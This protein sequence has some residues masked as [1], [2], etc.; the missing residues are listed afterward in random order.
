MIDEEVEYEVDLKLKFRGKTILNLQSARL[1]YYIMKYG[2]ILTASRILNIP[3]S[4]AWGIIDRIEKMLGEK[5]VSRTRG[6]SSGGGTTLMS[7]GRRLLDAYLSKLKSIGLT[8]SATTLPKE[9]DI[10][11]IGSDDTLLR[12]LIGKFAD[13]SSK[14]VEYH[15][16]GS[17]GGILHI[18]IGDADIVVAH[19]YDPDSG[20]YNVPFIKRVG[21]E[22]T[23]HILRGYIRNIVLAF[24]DKKHGSLRDIISSVGSIAMRGVG[25]GTYMLMDHIFK[26]HKVK[27][28]P[29]IIS[30]KTHHDA[31]VAVANGTMDCCVTIEYEA[32][33]NGLEYIPLKREYFDFIV[34]RDKINYENV[35]LFLEFLRSMTETIN[36]TPGYSTPQNFLH[37]IF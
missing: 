14:H 26:T 34:A 13:S 2:S 8:I 23:V 7:L 5:I 36:N 21:L 22:D 9:P 31:A 11:I 29:K 32:I 24:K 12:M 18:V 27:H 15:V 3:Y 10:V 20:E 30:M 25:S 19:M 28:K 33:T 4:K 1:L 35:T 6:G 17:L 37:I 16:L